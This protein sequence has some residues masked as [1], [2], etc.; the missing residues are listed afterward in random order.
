MDIT[1]GSHG[2]VGNFMNATQFVQGH[3]EFACGPFATAHVKFATA[4]SVV[5]TFTQAQLQHWAYAEYVQWIGPDTP[6]DTAGS[7]IDNMHQFYSDARLH[8]RDMP[9]DATSDHN[10]DIARIKAALQAGYPVI[11]TVTE[12]S[13]FDVGLGKNP[14]WWGPAGTHIIVYSGIAHS[15]NVLVQDTAN[16]LGA[17]QGNNWAQPGPREYLNA[18]L[19]NS[20]GAIIQTS[21]LKPIPSGDPLTWPQG[22]NAQN[23]VAPDPNFDK[24]A[25]DCWESVMKAWT[26][27]PPMGTGIF[28]AWKAAWQAGKHYGPPL[29][30]EYPSVNTAGQAI[31]VQEF[32][33]ARCEWDGQAHWF[34]INGNA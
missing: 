14:Y 22:F 29:T 8:W 24:E 9:I 12:A 25:S 17:L 7:S 2:E 34:S 15:G 31:K 18:N 32:A 33:H 10:Q 30:G 4:P 1:L 5:N 16:V 20:Y 3:D 27:P 19:D 21:W 28:Q 13:V 23:N 26:A 11:A 6:S